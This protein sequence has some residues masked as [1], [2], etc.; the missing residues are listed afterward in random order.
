MAAKQAKQAKQARQTKHHIQPCS[1]EKLQLITYEDAEEVSIDGISDGREARCKVLRV[2]DGD[3]IHI[4]VM[5]VKGMSRVRCRLVDYD[6]HEPGR[7]LADNERDQVR[8]LIDQKVVTVTFHGEGAYWRPQIDVLLP[9]NQKLSQWM[10][11]H[12]TV[13]PEKRK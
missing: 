2:Y 10:L 11:D 9:R 3:T 12:S 5:T 6:A 4:G 7:P 13:K 1:D 8:R